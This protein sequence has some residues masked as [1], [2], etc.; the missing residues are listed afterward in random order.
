MAAR[1]LTDKLTSTSEGLRMYQQERTILAV[2]EM[3][4]EIMEQQN[5][6]RAELAARLGKTKGF[7][8]QVLDGTAN[9]TMRTMSDIL[10]ELGH[11]ME[12]TA[13]PLSSKSASAE[14][15]SGT[16]VSMP[17]SIDAPE[18]PEAQFRVAAPLLVIAKRGG[19]P[20]RLA[21]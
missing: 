14:N 12:P 3:L 18:W 11:Q 15:E 20:D 6:S 9:M 21:G 5:V 10:T 4:C 19:D 17:V 8:S 13:A 7:I 1:T 2:T 16:V